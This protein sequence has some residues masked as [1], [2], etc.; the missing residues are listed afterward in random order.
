MS[1]ITNSLLQFLGVILV[2]SSLSLE[3]PLLAQ[4]RSEGAEQKE[5]SPVNHPESPGVSKTVPLALAPAKVRVILNVN[6]HVVDLA[7]RRDLEREVT[8]RLN[9]SLGQAIDLKL[10][11]SFRS[12]ESP[13]DAP[14]VSP[15]LHQMNDLNQTLIAFYLDDHENRWRIRT[16]SW[17]ALTNQWTEYPVQRLKN[18]EAIGRYLCQM[19]SRSI[20]SV[21]KVEKIEQKSLTGVLAGGEFFTPDESASLLQPGR[22]LGVVML[23]F[24]RNRQLKARQI[25][26]WTYLKVTNRNRA[27]ITCQTVSAF[28]NPIPKSRRRVEVLAFSVDRPFSET[29]ARVMIRDKPNRPFR[30]TKVFLSSWES[31]KPTESKS[32]ASAVEG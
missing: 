6:P 16:K 7:M 22:F 30:L 19:V 4:T 24:D 17:I 11:T 12:Y 23:Y 2:L 32:P 28:R 31:P 15:S 8:R 10:E 14:E 21:V 29:I 26:P 20:S 25:L 27:I 13:L 9:N 5:V 1:R 18:P 3:G